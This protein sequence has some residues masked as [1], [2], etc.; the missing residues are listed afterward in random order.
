MNV[1]ECLLFVRIPEEDTGKSFCCLVLWRFEWESL[2]PC[3][4]HMEKDLR[5]IEG[6]KEGE[7][8][9]EWM[10]GLREERRERGEEGN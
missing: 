10:K 1:F 3:I 4:L 8:R 7:E 9:E 5:G 6:G 2:A